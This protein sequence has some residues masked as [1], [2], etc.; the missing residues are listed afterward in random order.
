MSVAK[1][2]VLDQREIIDAQN[3]IAK[4]EGL[5]PDQIRVLLEQEGYEQPVIDYVSK[6]T[7]FDFAK[8][9]KAVPVKVW[10]DN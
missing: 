2:K 6:V 5:V 3:L 8:K 10:S 1:K 9:Y 7:V 4:T